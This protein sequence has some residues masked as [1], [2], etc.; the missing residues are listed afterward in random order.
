MKPA[1]TTTA[2]PEITSQTW[3]CFHQGAAWMDIDGV[4]ITSL[5]SRNQ[6]HGFFFDVGAPAFINDA[7]HDGVRPRLR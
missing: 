6:E 1:T 5:S 2:G 3:P 4:F 7:E